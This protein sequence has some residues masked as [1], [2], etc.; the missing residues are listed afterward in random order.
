MTD[1]N[2]FGGSTP[3][4]DV[5]RDDCGIMAAVV[6]GVVW[7]FCQMEDGVCRA[8]QSTIATRAGI[9]NASARTHLK[10]LVKAKYLKSTRNGQG[11]IYEDTG[12]VA[13]NALNSSAD[14]AKNKRDIALNSSDK[15]R[16]LRKNIKKE[17]SPSFVA[18]PATGE[19]G[20]WL[21]KFQEM[22]GIA[23]TRYNTYKAVDAIRKMIDAGGTI[24]HFEDAYAAVKDNYTIVSPA[25]LLT[26]TINTIRKSSNQP[27]RNQFGL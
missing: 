8:G 27:E 3:A 1:I 15:E 21:D 18:E 14:R 10:A 26:S 7:R 24:K 16:I 20:K 6:F 19:I 13:T 5:I 12:L 22:T 9:S 17:D 2:Q 25:S 11:I 4:P 23:E